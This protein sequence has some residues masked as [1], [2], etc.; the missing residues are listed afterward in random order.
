MAKVVELI[1]GEVDGTERA[2][3]LMT[4]TGKAIRRPYCYLYPLECRTEEINDVKDNELEEREDKGQRDV[5]KRKAAIDAR[6][7]MQI[8]ED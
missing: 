6:K 1:K 5:P 3:K 2:A 4:H 7:R 8:A